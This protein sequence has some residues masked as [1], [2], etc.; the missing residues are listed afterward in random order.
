MT[1]FFQG[2][3][4]AALMLIGVAAMGGFPSGSEKPSGYDAAVAGWMG[5]ALPT[6]RTGGNTALS[7]GA[8]T[9]IPNAAIPNGNLWQTGATGTS[10]DIPPQMV[11]P[12]RAEERPSS[13]KPASKIREA[14]NLWATAYTA[15]VHELAPTEESI[16]RWGARLFQELPSR[17]FFES[18]MN[19]LKAV[20]AKAVYPYTP[21]VRRG[22]LV[23]MKGESS[24]AMSLDGLKA[25]A[26]SLNPVV[27]Y[28]DPLNLAQGEFWDQTNEATI[29]WLRE[30]EIKHGRIAM[31][32][33]VG[34]CVHANG[35]RW[36]WHG[37]WDTIPTDISPQEMWDLQPESA[38]WQIIA[39]IGF[40]EFWRESS[41]VLAQEGEAHYMRGGKPG[42]MP[43]FDQIPHPVPF[44]CS[45]HS[46]CPRGRRRRR[47]P[48]A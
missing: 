7:P 9:S 29:A 14:W 12:L 39:T 42:F 38:K 16:K 46:S 3:G 31:F 23:T 35:I 36:P 47:R 44:S 40:F 4:L 32:G 20:Q 25:Q 33:F 27:G 15:F 6:T 21:P 10:A 22:G 24:G 45:T 11:S 1:W 13:I 41:Y 43:S 34:Y 37:P 48:R 19:E 26:K 5:G 17:E 8:L 28:F 18:Q 2:M 30:S